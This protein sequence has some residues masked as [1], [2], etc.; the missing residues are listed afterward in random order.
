MN[1]EE[2]HEFM[3]SIEEKVQKCTNVTNENLYLLS[4]KKKKK[5]LMKI[6]KYCEQ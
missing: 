1:K 2:F 5:Q 4:Q 3:I 6:N